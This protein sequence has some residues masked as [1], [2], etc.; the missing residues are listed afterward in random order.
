MRLPPHRN[1]E[2]RGNTRLS[3]RVPTGSHVPPNFSQILGH[4]YGQND[5]DKVITSL[6]ARNIRKKDQAS[7]TAENRCTEFP[8]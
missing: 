6:S 4:F 1:L 5:K 3:A 8:D 7:L 2:S